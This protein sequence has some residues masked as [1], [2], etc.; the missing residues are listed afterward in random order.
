MNKKLRSPEGDMLLSLYNLNQY[1]MR[2]CFEAYQMDSSLNSL[3]ETLQLYLKQLPNSHN[4]VPEP[5]E[6]LNPTP[7]PAPAL[8]SVPTAAPSFSFSLNLMKPTQIEP[9]EAGQGGQRSI[10]PD[11]GRR[12][13]P[14]LYP[15]FPLLTL[16]NLSVGGRLTEAD[17]AKIF[18]VHH[19]APL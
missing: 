14:F 6:S 7:V 19:R 3:L 10:S 15:E 1:I 18:D 8:A 17:A 11:S 13:S 2:G 16:L 9:A 12:V 5:E 4:S